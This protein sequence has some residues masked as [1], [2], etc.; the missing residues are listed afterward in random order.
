[1]ISKIKNLKKDDLVRGSIIL[2]MMMALFNILNY[3]FQMAM[4][5]MLGPADYGVLAV[6]M[7]IV[8]IFGI[9]SEAIQTVITRYVSKFEIKKEY[10]KTKD[11]FIRSLKKG[12]VLSFILFTLFIFASIFLSDILRIK[13][14]LL[15]ITGIF[16]F[17]VFS[18]PVIRGV[19]QGE[20]KFFVLGFNM[21]F[22]SFLK[23]VFSIFL[24]FVGFEVYGAIGSLLVGCLLAFGLALI[25]MKNVWRAK[26]K[27]ANIKNLYRYNVPV[28]IGITAIVLVYSLDIIFARIFFTPELAGKYS[29]ISLIGKVVLFSSFAISKTMF[30]IASENFEKGRRTG[31]ILKK[32]VLLVLAIAFVMVFLCYFWPKQVISMLSLGSSQYLDASNILFILC[33]AFSF[34]ALSN[35]FINYALSINKMRKSSLV[36]IVFVILEAI[37]L[38]IFN[39]N[40]VEFA[41]ALL[42]INLIMFIYTVWVAKR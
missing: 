1:M 15:A 35:I 17:Y 6:L 21:V 42:A 32:S 4:A 38:S 39:S 37:M 22:E 13:I 34:T 8:Y 23:V 14:G 40:L 31:L 7:S 25:S 12:A 28:L 24:V 3:I 10:G 19:L 20:K 27:K 9:P 2:F 16:I 41:V 36:L 18:V 33:L 30:P 11:L 29:F 26:R 5:R